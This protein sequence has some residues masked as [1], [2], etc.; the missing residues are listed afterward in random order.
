MNRR[1]VAALTAVLTLVAT[2]P[3]FAGA[4]TDDDS[5]I[6]LTAFSDIDGHLFENAIVWLEAQGITSGCNPPANTLFCPNQE[7]T[8][9]QMAV[10]L[11]RALNLKPPLQNHFIDD[12]GAF[13]EGSANRLREA[14]ITVGCNPPLNNRFCGND[15]VTRQEMAT[16][17]VRGFKIPNTNADYF[18]DDETSVHEGNINRIRAANVTVGCNPPTNNRF[19]PRA[20][21]TRGQ[22]ATF[23]KRA[24]ESLGV[25][26]APNPTTTTTTIP[27]QTTTTT[28]P[29]NPCANQTIP[30]SEC[31][32]LVTFYTTMDGPNWEAP[33]EVSPTMPPGTAWLTG[34][35]CNWIGIDCNAGFNNVTWLSLEEF[36]L[37][38]SFHPSFANLTQL[39]H[40]DLG[41][42]DLSGSIAVL[43][44]LTQLNFLNLEDTLGL[45]LGLS[46]LSTLVNLQTA[47]LQNNNFS[48]ALPNLNNL[49]HLVDLDLTAN[50]L[51]SVPADMTGLIALLRLDLSVNNFS[52]AVPAGLWTIPSLDDLDLS[53]NNFTSFGTLPTE[54]STLDHLFLGANALNGTIPDGLDVFEELETLDLSDNALDGPIPASIGGLSNLTQLDLSVNTL[55]PSTIPLEFTDLEALTNLEMCSNGTFDYADGP[56]GT[57][58]TFVN[59][60]D[61]NHNLV[62]PA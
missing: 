35:A 25:P 13:Y 14:G 21:V 50:E 3:I 8:R 62:C 10:F 5:T 43:G 6:P 18:I 39:Q 44:T 20:A 60:L 15:P 33:T 22:M 55:A 16:F 27:G 19:C 17:L 58:F 32:A 52:G 53:E 9:G 56:A 11:S 40:L 1:L 28:L 4:A 38:G 7:V 29:P 59:T 51:T 48:G 36:N 26:P 41:D 45:S 61:P 57:V 31:Q 2:L 47:N 34:N 23:L 54:T 37:T 42:N 46:A 30:Q 12:N 49:V 24:V